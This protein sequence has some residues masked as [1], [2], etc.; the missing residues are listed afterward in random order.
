[1]V[2]IE[3]IQTFLRYNDWADDEVFRA[4]EVFSD[5]QLDRAFEMGRGSLRK[6]LMH[7][8]CGE[9]VWVKRWQGHG[10][11]PWP[12]EDEPAAITVL[13]ERL[14]RVRQERDEFLRGL[15]G[16][17]LEKRLS[18]HDSLGGMFT[19]TLGEM[20]LQMCVHSTHHRAQAVNMI[21][22]LGGRAPDMDYMYW[23]RLPAESES[24]E[25]AE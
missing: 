20:M 13:A 10:Q 3:T 21:R 7:I 22:R 9:R 19:A 12:D 5:E 4:S 14:S 25:P 23:I 11:T 18:Y 2:S 16:G 17:E 15:G 24:R 8:L 6:T 1:M